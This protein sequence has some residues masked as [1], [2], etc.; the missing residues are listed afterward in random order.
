MLEQF[1]EIPADLASHSLSDEMSV[2]GYL[3]IRGLIPAEV[4]RSLLAEIGQIVSQAGWLVPGLDP[5]DRIANAAAACGD[6]DP[7]FK[8]IYQQI[9]GLESFHAL[10]HHPAL[11]EAMKQIAGPRLLVHPK[12]IGRFIFPNCEQ[13]IT[14][15]HQDH[16]GIGGDTESFT[17][18]MPL[19]DCPVELGPL[20]ILE[21]SHLFGLQETSAD[22]LVRVD[23][24][25]GVRWVGGRIDAGDVLIFHSLTVHAAT[26]NTSNQLR[27]SVD[28]RFQDLA[29]PINPAALVFPGAEPG[30]RSWE[31]AYAGWHS[32]ESQYYWRKLPVL[33]N[34]SLDELVQLAESAEPPQMRARYARILSQIESQMLVEA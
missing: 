8:Q 4:L 29:R 22:G 7:T 26:P 24:A 16:A 28:C 14:G 3:L 23:R 6:P 17:A 31:K 15:A 19:H 9:F 18:W 32:D 34:P 21:G 5:M 20:Q 27:V 13:L 2:R 10:A 1:H 33:L 12:S 11:Q 25:R 30:G